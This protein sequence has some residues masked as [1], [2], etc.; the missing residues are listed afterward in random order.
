MTIT[1]N[2]GNLETK[3]IVEV[4]GDQR[5]YAGILLGVDD[6]NSNCRIKYF[7]YDT[8]VTVPIIQVRRI[9]LGP[10]SKKDAIIG[11]KC[12]CKYSQD[13]QYYDAT[14][15]QI[16]EHGV[17][18]TYTAYG[19]TE[20]VPIAYL[21]PL[22]KKVDNNTNS[23]E[24]KL[25][26]IPDKLKIL[27]TDT[28]KEKERKKRIVKSI[29]SKNKIIEKEVELQNVQQSWQKFVQKG[30]KKSLAG[31]SKNSQFTTSDNITDRVGVRNSGVTT[32]Y[33]P[34]KKHKFEI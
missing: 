18:V 10:V 15:T 19:N 34:R 24:P 16:T 25:I 12:L 7:E 1:I 5:V 17:I 32:S 23:N 30:S 28:D 9:A 33:Q 29:K 20:E 2:K 4:I 31:L 13:Q 3:E 26:K 14:I 11:Y 22:K 27:P 21:K 8:E 6:D